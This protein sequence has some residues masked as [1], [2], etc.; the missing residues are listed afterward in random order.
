VLLNRGR[1][2]S[3]EGYLSRLAGR[4]GAS[5]SAHDENREDYTDVILVLMNLEIWCR[6]FLDQRSVE[7]VAGELS[8]RAR[9]A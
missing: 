6:L 4:R 5:C 9:A 3:R 2:S 1:A 7:D 8:E